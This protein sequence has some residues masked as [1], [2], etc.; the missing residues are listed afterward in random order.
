MKKIA[1]TMT[2][3]SLLIGGAAYAQT[4]RGE[5]AAATRD[6]VAERTEAMFARMDA[7]G[8]GVLDEADKTARMAKRFAQMDGNGD[9]MLSQ[10]EFTAAH[11]AHAAKREAR[12][13]RRGGERMGMRGQR[14]GRGGGEAMIKRADTN[15]D[16]QVTRAEFQ[17]AALAR[18]D[19]TDAD[20]DGTI[21]AD[22][23]KAARPDRRGAR[24]G[25]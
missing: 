7:N 16:G 1:L 2:A 5:K 12:G 20:G 21:S 13:E 4:A 23:R 9:G 11:E 8:D 24:D 3:A 15:S 17:A 25:Q 22:E 14:G 19:K 10:A 18:F 6:A